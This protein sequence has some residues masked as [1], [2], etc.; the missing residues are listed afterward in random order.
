MNV[1]SAQLTG[2]ELNG[3]ALS[4]TSYTIRNGVLTIDSVVLTG[5]LNTASVILEDGTRVSFSIIVPEQQITDEPASSSAGWGD[6]LF[7]VVGSIE[8]VVVVTLLVL[9]I[10]KRNKLKR[11]KK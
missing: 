11:T 3:V 9:V 7:Y 4:D 1:G 6:I 5:G 2:V 8:L 10:I